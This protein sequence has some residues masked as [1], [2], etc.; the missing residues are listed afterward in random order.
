V[1]IDFVVTG[2]YPGDGKSKPIAFP[3]PAKHLASEKQIKVVDLK[4]FIELKLASGMTA[5]KRLQDLADVQRLIEVHR[6]DK[7]FADTLHP[8]VRAKFLELL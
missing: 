2:E 4:T 8:Y 5:P 3:D 6:L 1:R 7:S